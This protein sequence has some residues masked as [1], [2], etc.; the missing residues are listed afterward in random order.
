MP[1]LTSQIRAYAE[2]LDQEAPPVEDLAGSTPIRV[3][4]LRSR[5]R[6]KAWAALAAALVAVVAAVGGVA[7]LTGDAV[8]LAAST[9][10]GGEPTT[11]AIADPPLRFESASPDPV[12]VGGVEGDTWGYPHAGPGAIVVVDGVFHALRTGQGED[13]PGDQDY[14]VGVGV[15]YSTSVDGLSWSEPVANPLFTEEAV[16]YAGDFSVRSVVVRADGVW[17]MYFDAL[18]DDGGDGDREYVWSIGR[19]TASLPTG[20]WIVD[21]QPVLIPGVAGSWDAK[22]VAEPIVIADENGYRMY[23]VG[24][25]GE[26]KL[27]AVGLARSSDGITWVKDPEPV[28]AGEPEGWEEGAI[29]RADV[30]VGPEGWV[31]TYAGRTGGNR[32][33]AFSDDGITWERHPANPIF[34]TT[35]TPRASIFG[36]KIVLVG[37]EYHWFVQ[38]GGA[39]STSDV[40]LYIHPAPIREG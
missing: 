29:A 37:E 1:D 13:R 18:R 12:F 15:G 33:V 36:S 19:A 31:M 2:Q 5:P 38:S 3:A 10:T 25:A 21:E 26:Q 14:T 6:V 35:M 4:P 7:L 32:G 28:F 8:D 17:M 40:R 27:G 34:D 9:T 39:R 30:L 16:P 23:Y 20:P 11:V 22:A 24:A